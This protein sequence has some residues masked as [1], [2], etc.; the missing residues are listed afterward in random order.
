MA[1]QENNLQNSPVPPQEPMADG[2]DTKTRKTVRLKPSAVGPGSIK[3]PGAPTPAG[4]TP[5]ADPLTGRDTDT[6]N[7]EVLE[8][9]QTRRTVK[10]KPVAPPTA[11]SPISL[12]AGGAASG[13]A[14]ENTQTRKT[15]VL[16]PSVLSPSSVKVEGGAMENTQTRKT[17]VLKPSVLSPS[18]VK[19]APNAA[20]ETPVESSDTIKIARP[21][22]GPVNPAKQTVVLPTA[23]NAAPGSAPAAPGKAT[24]KL[25]PPP[26]PT[27]PGAAPKP[28]QVT[29][30]KAPAA[31]PAPPAAPEAAKDAKPEEKK[32]DAAKKLDAKAIVDTEKSAAPS[33]LYL[34]LAAVS[35]ILMIGTAVITTVQ[36]LNIC[37]GQKIELP[38]L[39][40]K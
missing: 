7:L 16:K 10:L 8:D 31:P 2:D 17:V 12:Q 40:N 34:V 13:S 28:P 15:V 19:V 1:D 14:M 25:T 37:Q 32:E 21:V 30:P 38:G 24:V 5:L 3:L 39:P 20:S 23:N 26:T 36:Y 18:S 27:A 33:R 4:R 9:T 11:R 35:L 6:G 22:R 29:A